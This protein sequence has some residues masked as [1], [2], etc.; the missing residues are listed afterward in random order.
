MKY[1]I[2]GFAQDKLIELE[3]DVSDALI[4][5]WFIDFAGTGNMKRLIKYI[6]MLN[7][8]ES[9]RIFQFLVLAVPKEFRNALI[10]MWKKDFSSKQSNDRAM[11]L[12]S[13]LHQQEHF[14][15]YNIIPRWER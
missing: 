13:S 8:L 9:F 3:L 7:I 11:G 2:E 10:A 15:S 6:T 5:R 14:S 4:L 12:Y 1:T